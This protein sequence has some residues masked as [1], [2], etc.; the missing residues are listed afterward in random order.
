MIVT[1]TSYVATDE[2]SNVIAFPKKSLQGLPVL[3]GVQFGREAN[4]LSLDPVDLE[5]GQ[6]Y[7]MHQ[8]YS[9]QRIKLST[10]ELRSHTFITGSTGS[11]KSNTIYTLLNALTGETHSKSIKKSKVHFLV[12]EPAKG[13]YKQAFGDRP[14]VTC[15]STNPKLMDAHMLRI[16]PFSF[17][18][19]IHVLEHMDRLVE[20]FN[21]CWPMYAAMP[22]ILKD[23]IERSYVEAGWDLI[24]SE[25][26]YDNAIFPSFSD[27]VKQIRLVLDSSDY[28]ADNKG[29]YTGALVT[30]L[31]S[32]TNGINGQVFTAEALPDE[33][34]FD[35]N[36][37]I[38]LSRVGSSETK[39]LIMGILVLKLQ[40][41]RMQYRKPNSALNHITVLEEAHN[42]LKKTSTDQTAEGSNMLG[43]SVEM[44]ANAIAEMRTY[45]EGFIIADQ[46]PGL[47]DMSVIRNTNTKIIVRLPDYSDRELVGRAAGLN[48][49]QIVELGRLERGVAAI[50]QSN[51]LEPVLCKIDLF[52]TPNSRLDH[53]EREFLG[54]TELQ[55]ANAEETILDCIMTKELYR[56]GDRIDI[57]KLKDVIIR[58]KMS[59]TIK[60]DLLDYI[61]TGQEKAVESLR[62]LVYDFFEAGEAIQKSRDSKTI[63]EWVSNVV[64]ELNPS[65]K[66]Y[67]NQQIDLLLA[68]IIYEQTL[69]DRNYENILNSYT[70]LYRSK[71]GVY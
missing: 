45:G 8:V 10:Q 36:A 49:E 68:L 30:R 67:S 56:K 4:S 51:W 27:V 42:L 54:R 15:F 25:N 5:I 1:G 19:N 53:K 13:E 11:G 24:Q 33:E 59:A 44:L 60:C 47:L 66:G 18:P 69:R 7:H 61:S 41:H 57:Q 71:G 20:I 21:V 6:G 26:R 58:S 9:H 63:K 22:A 65:V 32:L 38:D 35:R 31:R 3:E 43:K 70:E 17:P 64:D 37:I 62:K 52:D 2:L 40:E 29:D 28:S 14:D 34:L 12:V 50:T 55:V 16:N 46:S 48:E 23:A 39:S